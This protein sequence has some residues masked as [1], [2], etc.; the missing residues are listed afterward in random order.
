MKPLIIL[1]TF[2]ATITALLGDESKEAFKSEVIRIFNEQDW[3][4]YKALT[5][6]EG[7]TEYDYQMMEAV[8][9]VILD[10]QKV[11][12][13]TFEALPTGTKNT[14]IHDGREFR[15]TIDPEGLLKLKQENGASTLRYAKQEGRYVLVGTKSE[16]LGWEGPKDVPLGIII[17]GH[18]TKDIAIKAS[19]NASGRD[20]TDAF[21]HS[22]TNFFGQYVSAVTVRSNNPDAVYQLR[23]MEDGNIVYQ[24]EMKTGL[25]KIEY[26]R[27]AQALGTKASN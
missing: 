25:G 27:N 13:A 20:F 17:L 12:S 24:S 3:E 8:K 22:S 11:L 1:L 16:D 2:L 18:N 7:M 14:F 6:L 10:G 26:N 9:P 21:D 4:A 23:I 5:C 19:W 15:P